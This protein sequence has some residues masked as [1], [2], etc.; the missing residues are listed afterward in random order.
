VIGGYDLVFKL[1]LPGDAAQ[2][3][4]RTVSQMWPE[5]IAENAGTNETFPVRDLPPLSAGSEFFVY[6]DEEVKHAWDSGE[7]GYAENP[8]MVHMLVDE[9][10]FT[11][12]VDSP[13]SEQAHM[14][15]DVFRKLRSR[16]VT[17]VLFA[18]EA[19]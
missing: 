9:H 7:V 10:E 5:A 18:E 14:A 12:V 3:I 11:I 2:S 1:R 17:A 6:R 8:N 13:K 19:A 16:H 4:A 15:M